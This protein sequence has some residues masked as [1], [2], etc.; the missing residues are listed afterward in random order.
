MSILSPEELHSLD[1]LQISTRRSI[2][3]HKQGSHRS[4]K[5][6]SGLEFSEFK[7]YTPGDDFRTIDWNTSA[8]TDKF[9]SR[10][11]REEQNLT[12]IIV[13]D[14]SK[15]LEFGK[16]L[17]LAKK[18]A[19]SL[20]YLSLRSGDKVSLVIPGICS[21][22]ASSK[23][24]TYHILSK[25]IENSSCT[26][27]E[28]LLFSIRRA[29]SQNQLPG[30][31]VLISDYLFDLEQVESSLSYVSSKNFQCSLICL[32]YEE[33]SGKGTLI[34]SESKEELEREITEEDLLEL[35]KLRNI[36]FNSLQ[37]IASHFSSDFVSLSYQANLVQVLHRD[38]I[39]NK[40]LI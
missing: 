6:G 24:S 21:T 26:K 29:L 4:N 13:L 35:K 2:L 25:L 32:D 40:V 16:N 20:I 28:D 38:L 39:R 22:K 8:R 30:R 3:G 36:H 37:Q 31:I 19:A 17:A 5:K 27:Q 15:S 9:Y 33:E 18:L 11:F 23:S 10:I 34:D 14:L 1:R 7:Q 12:L